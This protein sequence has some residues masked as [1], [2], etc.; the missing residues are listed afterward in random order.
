[1]DKIKVFDNFFWYSLLAFGLIVGGICFLPSLLTSYS[2]DYN[3]TATGQIGD[4]IGG[5]MGPFVGIA[6]AILTF[7][8]FWVQ[9]KANEQQKVDLKEQRDRAHLENFQNTF[10]ELIKLHKENINELSY[11]KYD[12]KNVIKTENRRVFRAI[13]SE[14]LECYREVKKYSN[15]IDPDSY[16]LPD[17]KLELQTV[18]NKKN[19]EANLIELSIIDIAYSVTFFGLDNSGLTILSERFEKRY[20]NDYYSKLLLYLSIKPKRE[21]EDYLAIWAAINKLKFQEFQNLLET[22]HKLKADKKTYDEGISALGNALLSGKYFRKYYDGHQ[23]R[24]GHY[25]RHLF[26]TYIFLDKSKDLNDEQIMFYGKI[27]RAQLSTYEQALLFINC[28]SSLGMKW[29][30]KYD[31]KNEK[32]Q[33]TGLI[34]KYNLIRNLPG[35]NFTGIIFKNYFP[36]VNFE[37]DNE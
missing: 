13:F 20:N 14:F 24:L 21:S 1:M 16:L 27:L 11:Y 25:F 28:V 30:L 18:I 5:T 34:S 36:N 17:Y 6:A 7:L 33:S 22:V 8:A 37:N 19:I 31:T 15:S 12:S 9:F 2:K 23:H 4:T 32:G 29:E 26:Q 35:N 10:F 3:F